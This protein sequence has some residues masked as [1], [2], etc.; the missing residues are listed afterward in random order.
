MFFQVF[1]YGREKSKGMKEGPFISCGS[2]EKCEDKNYKNFPGTVLTLYIF[3]NRL[4]TL[5]VGV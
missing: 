2:P 5:L 1:S 4:T 3:K